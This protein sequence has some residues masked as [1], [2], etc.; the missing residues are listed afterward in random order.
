MGYGEILGTTQIIHALIK[1]AIFF[2]RKI[3][4]LTLFYQLFVDDYLLKLIKHGI[5]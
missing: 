1:S 4:S 3:N 5:T 2:K